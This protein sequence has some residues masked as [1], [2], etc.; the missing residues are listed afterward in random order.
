MDY[1]G[2]SGQDFFVLYCLQKKRNGT[3][4]EIG[5]NDPIHINNTYSLEKDY[6]WKGFMVE[7]DPSFLNK[8]QTHRPNSYWI[9]KD[10]TTVDFLSEFLFENGNY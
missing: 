9:M 7:Y 5:S 8:Y 2:Q 3:Y 10:A 6:G 4:L 1:R